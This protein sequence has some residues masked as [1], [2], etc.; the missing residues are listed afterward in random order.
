MIEVLATA[1]LCLALGF[2]FIAAYF[3]RERLKKLKTWQI[4]L[5]FILSPLLAIRE[6]IIMIAEK[7][8]KE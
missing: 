4:T 2:S 8:N 7:R 1:Y 5:F 3:L 6:A